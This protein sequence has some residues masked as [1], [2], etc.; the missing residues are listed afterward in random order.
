M[1][2]MQWLDELRAALGQQYGS[3]PAVMLLASVDPSGA[4]H[5]RCLI[6]R[7]IDETGR[8]YAATDSRTDKNAQLRADRRAELVF[9]L[10]AVSTQF[11]LSGEARIIAFPEDEPLRRDIW[12]SLSDQERST[13]FWPTPG[14]AA[15][16]DDLFTQA[17]AADVAPPRTFEVL[18]I[19]PK[20]VDRLS[21][22]YHPHRRRVWRAINEWV[23]VDV[24]P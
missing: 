24:N 10:P 3:Q 18:V 6:C 13:Y 19:E 14:I 21:M 7:R 20:Q 23:G 4:P 1:P 17:V 15:A 22:C 9:W 12:R 5:A 16:S 8:I 2:A 11:R